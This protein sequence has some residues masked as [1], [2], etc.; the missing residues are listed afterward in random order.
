MNAPTITTEYDS[1]FEEA[2]KTWLP[3][4]NWLWLKVQ[5]Y[6][7]SLLQSD[8]VSPVGAQGI[9]QFMP[10]TWEDVSFRLRYPSTATPFN[11]TYAIPAGAYYMALMR[12]GWAAERPEEDRRNL[13]FASYNAGFGSIL[14][15]QK[16][17][18]GKTL[19]QDI[20]AF[21]PQ[22]TNETKDGKLIDNAKQTA[23]YVTRINQYYTQ[24]SNG[25]N[26][27]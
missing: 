27:A 18:G 5:A 24:F 17:S 3:Q 16:L 19:Y 12:N 25:V 10:N 8:A 11:P 1:L 2:M 20:I 9:M 6:A 21:L 23:D 26:H 13:A 14:E 15:A 4:W 22:V 7:E